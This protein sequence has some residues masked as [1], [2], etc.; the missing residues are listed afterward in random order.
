MDC[1][2]NID[3]ENIDFSD[4]FTELH[5]LV[6]KDILAG[7]GFGIEAARPSINLVHKIREAMQ[8]EKKDACHPLIVGG[9]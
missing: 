1:Q 5:T 7:K 8:V 6:Y 2:I 3:G 4:G 9:L